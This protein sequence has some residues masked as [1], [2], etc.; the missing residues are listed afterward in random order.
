MKK[1][2]IGIF[3]LA[4]FASPYFLPMP[5]VTSGFVAQYALGDSITFDIAAWNVSPLARE[6]KKEGAT[7][8][9]LKIDGQPIAITDTP[10]SA[11]ITQFSRTEQTVS[12]RISKQ[13]V[14]TPSFNTATGEIELPEGR[15]DISVEWLGS[16]SFSHNI[17]I[18]QI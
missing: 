12:Y 4:L 5:L 17:S 3:V 6:V 11:Q 15:H 18:V 2:F 14:R 10:A 16:S 13:V 1:L 8:I 7:N 9:I